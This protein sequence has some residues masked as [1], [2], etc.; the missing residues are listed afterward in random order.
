MSD[1][2]LQAVRQNI[3]RDSLVG[4]QELLICPESAQHHVADNQQRP[5][6]A[7]YLHRGIQRTSR[8]PLGTRLP[9]WHFLSLTYFNLHF[10]SD[11][12]HTVS[13]RRSSA[14]S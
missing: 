6:V 5:A 12:L 7:Q 4:S 11:L 14:A 9:F 13:R 8:P 2:L 1:Q 10:A 3:R